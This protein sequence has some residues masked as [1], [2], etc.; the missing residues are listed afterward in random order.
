MDG[1]TKTDNKSI[2]CERYEEGT[3][4]ST[5]LIVMNMR[6]IYDPEIHINIYD[7][8]LIYDIK[9]A[10]GKVDVTMTLTSVFCPVADHLVSQVKEAAEMVLGEGNANVTVTFEPLW[11]VDMIPDHAKLEIGLL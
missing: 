2:H 10:D 9:I 4:I 1:H 5:D 3:N 6:E 7:L 11:G 8:G